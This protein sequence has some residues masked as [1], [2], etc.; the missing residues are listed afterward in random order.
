MTYVINP[1]WFYFLGM[2]DGLNIISILML[3]LG[4]LL[5]IGGATIWAMATDDEDN[6]LFKKVLIVGIII[7]VLG[8]AGSIF[9]PSQSTL[10]KMMIA[11][12][13]T[14]ER[15]EEVEGKTYELVDYIAEKVAEMKEEE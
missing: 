8:V 15:V 5:I 10:E 13:V 4:T 6:K 3:I 1:W 9:I 7:S 11:S 14:E 2:A 12:F